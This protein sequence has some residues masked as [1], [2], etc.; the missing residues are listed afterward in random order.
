MLILRERVQDPAI[1]GTFERRRPQQRFQ[2]AFQSPGAVLVGIA[3]DKQPF[4]TDRDHGTQHGFRRQRRDGSNQVVALA[5]AH[6]CVAPAQ[7]FGQ[8]VRLEKVAVHA[9]VHG[10]SFGK[11]EIGELKDHGAGRQRFLHLPHERHARRI[12]L[13]ELLVPRA[14]IHIGPGGLIVDAQNQQCSQCR[15]ILPGAAA[16]TKPS[17][18]R[19]EE[20][21]DCGSSAKKAMKMLIRL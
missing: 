21:E 19:I 10:M 16:A 8:Q 11:D 17:Q 15:P 3:V 7:R 9:L 1:I 2:S 14:N 6:G 5:S 18:Q 4:V 13:L 12:G 20:Q